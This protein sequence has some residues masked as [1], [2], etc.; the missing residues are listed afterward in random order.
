MRIRWI[1]MAFAVGIVVAGIERNLLAAFI[2][3]FGTLILI[4]LRQALW[5]ILEAI[6]IQGNSPVNRLDM[7]PDVARSNRNYGARTPKS[8]G[9][10]FAGDLVEKSNQESFDAN[11]PKSLAFEDPIKE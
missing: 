4:S 11:D 1:L 9:K 7:W 2:T 10:M 8:S 5:Q 6:R 3:V